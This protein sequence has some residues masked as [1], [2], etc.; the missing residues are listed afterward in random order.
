MLKAAPPRPSLSTLV[1]IMLVKR[2]ALSNSEAKL[3][4][5]CPVKES[6]TKIVSTGLRVSLRVL[7]SVIIFK[8]IWVLPAVSKIIISEPLKL[9]AFIA[10]FAISIGN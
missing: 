7:I 1:N 5:I 2:T 10:L 8:S 6:A 3:T 4:A 9:A